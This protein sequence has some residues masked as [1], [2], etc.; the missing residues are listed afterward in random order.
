MKSGNHILLRGNKDPLCARYGIKSG[1]PNFP[2]VSLPPERIHTKHSIRSIYSKP[3]NSQ[4]AACYLTSQIFQFGLRTSTWHRWKTEGKI[5][6]TASSS[7]SSKCPKTCWQG[8][9]PPWVP[10]WR[11]IDEIQLKTP[12]RH[13]LHAGAMGSIDNLHYPCRADFVTCARVWSEIDSDCIKLLDSG[14]DF[15]SG[16]QITYYF[17]DFDRLLMTTG[18][19]SDLSASW[20]RVGDNAAA[21][22]DRFVNKIIW[23]T[24][25]FMFCQ[26]WIL[27]AA[28]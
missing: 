10:C 28:L 7:L 8:H 4:Q 17:F 1:K 15:Y 21:Q 20:G 5:K 25:V 13:F 22:H 27:I 2:N 19:K 12:Q 11:I 14:V 9:W 6:S 18:V 3:H 23:F 24:C 16:R 26:W